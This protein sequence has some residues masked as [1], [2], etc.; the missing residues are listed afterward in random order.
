MHKLLLFLLLALAAEGV[1]LACSCVRPGT[2]E[3]SRPLARQVVLGAVAIVE[4]EALS[5]YRP[6]GLGEQVRV[7]RVLWGEAPR[8]FRIARTAF[9]SG[10]SCDLLLAPGERTLLILYPVG[11]RGDGMG[12]RLGPGQFR[13]QSLCADFLLSEPGHLQVLIEEARRRGNASPP[14]GERG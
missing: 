12:R 5:E 7:H 11:A 8:E 1:A 13:I 10:A 6:G 14:R 9:D 3:E 2:P 4:A